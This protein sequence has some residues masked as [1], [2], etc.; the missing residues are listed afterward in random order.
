MKSRTSPR[1]LVP[2][3][4]PRPRYSVDMFF[5]IHAPKEWIQIRM[6]TNPMSVSFWPFQTI[7]YS[8]KHESH[9]ITDS[10]KSRST[11]TTTQ[12]L[13]QKL[14]VLPNTYS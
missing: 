5:L 2:Q 14:H 6:Y 13:L 10:T 11:P 8:F 1:A 9:E 7:F 4:G 12:T 3:P